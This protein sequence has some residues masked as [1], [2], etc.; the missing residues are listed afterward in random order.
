MA[1]VRMND[2]EC[3]VPSVWQLLTEIQISVL[4]IY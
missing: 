2:N 1:V 4:M 3:E